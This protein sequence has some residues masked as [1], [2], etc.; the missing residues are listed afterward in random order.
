MMTRGALCLAV[1]LFATP[2][3]AQIRTCE[4]INKT[5]NYKIVL[6]DFTLSGSD[7]PNIN[8]FMERVAASVRLSIERLRAD[9]QLHVEYVRCT[10]RRP[11]AE[12]DFDQPL[13][14]GLNARRV[15]IE[16]W[17]VGATTATGAT[18]SYHAFVKYVLVP[19]RHLVAGQVPDVVT[20]ELKGK[21]GEP[22]DGLVQ[23]FDQSTE[24]LAY[25]AA[26][27]GTKLLQEKNYDQA[28]TYLCKA[29]AMLATAKN[30]APPAALVKWVRDLSVKVMEQAWSD[31]NYT[32][33][34][35]LREGQAPPAC[36]K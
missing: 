10:M 27:L 29:D 26:S 5:Q 21:A 22:L 7:E 34:M 2:A 12:S 28:R 24:L 15:V 31:P 30:P 9:T 3:T 18:P 11:K 19:V 36:G 6:D 13:V 20:V 25:A 16:M 8:L 1:S 23:A 35:R 4:P 32:G 17:A 14:H 33:A